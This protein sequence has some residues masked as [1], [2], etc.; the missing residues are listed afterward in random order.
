[1]NI[2]GWTTL[3]GLA[4][5]GCYSTKPQEKN[6]MFLAYQADNRLTVSEC[7]RKCQTNSKAYSGILGASSCF[8]GD[9]FGHTSPMTGE[10]LFS[11]RI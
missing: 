5:T 6:D 2:S 9:E 1:M 3:E 11:E 4:S 8:C 10:L 7:S